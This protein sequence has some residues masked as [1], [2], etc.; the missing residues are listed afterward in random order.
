LGAG[1]KFVLSLNGS[2][3][4]IWFS[5]FGLLSEKNREVFIRLHPMVTR[6]R[7]HSLRSPSICNK[8]VTHERD[9]KNRPIADQGGTSNEDGPTF[10]LWLHPIDLLQRYIIC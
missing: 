1:K 4:K 10:A 6:P 3:G 2:A 8:S 9:Y 5:G 7:I